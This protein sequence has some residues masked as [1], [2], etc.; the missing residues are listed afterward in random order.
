MGRSL[1]R[2]EQKSDGE[3][4]SPQE[5]GAMNTLESFPCRSGWQVL[6]LEE[7]GQGEGC[8]EATDGL[9]NPSSRD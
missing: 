6:A 5:V 1:P 9:W 7:S 4:H 8:Q 3:N 2:A